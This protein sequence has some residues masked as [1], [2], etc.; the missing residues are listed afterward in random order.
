MNRRRKISLAGTIVIFALGYIAYSIYA[1]DNVYGYRS[2]EIY[3]YP[4][5]SFETIHQRDTVFSSHFWFRV[6]RSIGSKLGQPKVGR[7]VLDHGW[8]NRSIYNTLVSGSQTP[9][10]FKFT[11]L[12]SIERLAGIVGHSFLID[13]VD[14][15]NAI[16]NPD[17]LADIQMD[18]LETMGLLIPDTYQ[19]YWTASPQKILNKFVN[20]YKTYWNKERKTLAKNQGLTPKEVSTL[21]SIVINET[22]K[23]D[24]MPMVAGLYLNRLRKRHR[25]QADPTVKYALYQKDKTRQIKRILKRDLKIKSPFNTYRNYGLPPAPISSSSIDGIEAVLYAPRVDYLYMC[26]DPDNIGYHQFTKSYKQ[27]LRNARKYQKWLNSRNI[28]R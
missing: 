14:F 1:A 7:Y 26:A 4:G 27:H 11:Y 2:K 3:V 23:V 8:S 16:F 6:Y 10:D 28:Y 15:L 22:A 18:S 13:S 17:F 25:L 21:A 24:E 5:D 12:S 20:N 19:F 9:F